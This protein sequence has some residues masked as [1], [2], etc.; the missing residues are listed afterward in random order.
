VEAVHLT[1][2]AMATTSITCWYFL[3]GYGW[4]ISAYVP[5][6]LFSSIITA[7]IAGW[8]RSQ[9]TVQRNPKPPVG[10]SP[11]FCQA[12]TEDL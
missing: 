4:L 6:F 10:H 7:R 1:G 11:T 12:G 5:I 3:M 2:M 8:N 9:L